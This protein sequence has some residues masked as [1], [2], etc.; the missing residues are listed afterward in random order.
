M[1]EEAHSL[2]VKLRINQKLWS[3]YYKYSQ[4]CGKGSPQAIGMLQ[5]CIASG[6]QIEQENLYNK[7][8]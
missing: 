6:S 3:D 8:E 7:G 1:V 2:S 5:K 4:L